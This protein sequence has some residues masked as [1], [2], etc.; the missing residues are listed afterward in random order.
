MQKN[1]VKADTAVEAEMVQD[2]EPVVVRGIIQFIIPT[3]KELFNVLIDKINTLDNSNQSSR[4]ESIDIKHSL[5]S[6]E[7]RLSDYSPKSFLT[8]KKLNELY[9]ISESQQKGLRGR[10]KNP[11]PFYQDG[12]GG[13]IR[14]KVTDVDE[15][16]SQQKVK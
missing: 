10:I 6:I 9:A 3:E 14:Y 7:K 4:N 2:L 1:L 16:M 8:V 5:S 11:L 15:W 12:E 13:K